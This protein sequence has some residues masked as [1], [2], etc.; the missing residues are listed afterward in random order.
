MRVHISI[1]SFVTASSSG[2]RVL[3]YIK[4]NLPPQCIVL[5]R[6]SALSS[7]L[8]AVI[9]SLRINLQLKNTSENWFAAR[10]YNQTRIYQLARRMPLTHCWMLH[11]G[12]N[13]LCLSCNKPTSQT[14]CLLVHLGLLWQELV[15]GT[16]SRLLDFAI[17]YNIDRFSRSLSISYLT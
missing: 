7:L 17:S 3:P 12:G 6:V 4:T 16:N 2:W 5:T 10:I 9:D 11:I 15:T 1:V 13:F 8:L 14:Q